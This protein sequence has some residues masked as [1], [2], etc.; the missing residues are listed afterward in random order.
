M[1]LKWQEFLSFYTGVNKNRKKYDEKYERNHFIGEEIDEPLGNSTD[2][3]I[4][5]IHRQSS[6]YDMKPY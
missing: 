4:E 6:P 5:Q 3:E 1:N 2:E